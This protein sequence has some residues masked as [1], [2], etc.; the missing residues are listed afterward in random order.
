LK[1]KYQ[2]KKTKENKLKRQIYDFINHL[3]FRA[4]INPTQKLALKKAIRDYRTESIKN[5]K[6]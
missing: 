2:M 1:K 5:S 6:V 4:R 3:E